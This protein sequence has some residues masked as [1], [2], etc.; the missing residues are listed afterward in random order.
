MISAGLVEPRISDAGAVAELL[1]D[2]PKPGA[3]ALPDVGSVPERRSIARGQLRELGF[4]EREVATL[5]LGLK[6]KR[7]RVDVG[8]AGGGDSTHQLR[9]VVRAIGDPREDGHDVDADIDPALAK[10]S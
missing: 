10:T 1:H 9:Q 8:R 7:A 5:R 4:D 3:I 2:R 6:A